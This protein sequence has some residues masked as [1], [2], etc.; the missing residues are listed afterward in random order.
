ML[1]GSPFG[2]ERNHPDSLDARPFPSV[3]SAVAQAV[4]MD[5]FSVD[6]YYDKRAYYSEVQPVLLVL[7]CALVVEC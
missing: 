5:I 7:L 1:I 6:A 3:E 4:T 2:C